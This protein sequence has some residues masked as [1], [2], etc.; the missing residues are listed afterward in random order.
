[1]VTKDTQDPTSHP[2]QEHGYIVPGTGTE[3]VTTNIPPH[4]TSTQTPTQTAG[5]STPPKIIP[6][7]TTTGMSSG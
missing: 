3:I 1:M 7:T 6:I 5:D 4:P 2:T